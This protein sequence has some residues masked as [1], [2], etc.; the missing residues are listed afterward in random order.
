MNCMY[1]TV[2]L[3]FVCMVMSVC[4]CMY[5]YVLYA[6]MYV[7]TF[8]HCCNHRIPLLLPGRKFV[9][10]RV[11]PLRSQDA[12]HGRHHDGSELGAGLRLRELAAVLLRAILHLHDH[13]Q[14]DQV[15][16][17]YTYVHIYVHT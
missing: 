6:C 15:G 17:Y 4:A 3:P 13:S 16:R 14:A 8:D 7:I 2:Y 10:G 1:D 9:G 11:V 12:V 5:L